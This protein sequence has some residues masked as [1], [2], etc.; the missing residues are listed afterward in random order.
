MSEV[1]LNEGVTVTVDDATVIAAPID[2]TLTISG[3]AA[4]AKAVGDALALKADK[5][6]LSAQVSVNGQS[7]DAQ[8][9]IVVTGEDIDVSTTDTTKMNTKFAALDAKT[10]EDI[11]MSSESS[12]KTIAQAIE[13]GL[14]VTADQVPIA[15]GETTTVAEELERLDSEKGRVK[16]V[17]GK[18]PTSNGN[19]QVEEVAYARNLVSDAA[20]ASVGTFI[21]RM[22]GGGSS[23]SDGTAYL[24]QMRGNMTHTGVVAESFTVTV[25]ST[26]ED[27]ITAEVT[28]PETFRTQAETGGTYTF[29]YT[30]DAWDTDPSTWGM[31]VTGTPADGDVITVVWVE[32]DLGTITPAQPSDFTATGWN[33]YKHSNGYARVLK[34]DYKY[35]VGGTYTSLAY[36]ATPSGNQTAITVSDGTFDIPADGYVHVTG[37]TSTDTYITPEWQ[38]W[39]EGPSGSWA[40]YSESTI[41]VSSLFGTGKLFEYGLL[42]VENTYDIIDFEMGVATSK[43]GRMANTSVNMAAIIASGRAYDADEDYIYYVK[44]NADIT[45]EDISEMTGQFTASDHGIEMIGGTEVDVTCLILYG[46]NLKNKLERDCITKS[47]DIVDNLTSTATDKALSAKQ[48]KVLDEKL[49]FKAGDTFDTVY[50][51][52][53]PGYITSSTKTI[54]FT[55]MLPK[56]ASGRTVTITEMKGSVRGGSGYVDSLSSDATDLKSTYTVTVS[57]NHGYAVTISMVKS[58]AYANVTNNTPIIGSIKLTLTFA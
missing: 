57:Y 15:E 50:N 24:Q 45:T 54:L 47:Q 12:A 34:Y 13:D 56:D 48:G 29:T 17:N 33:L 22:S 23:V 43:I 36:S 1:N 28:T 42:A 3:D 38:D 10:A 26:A 41:D 14:N 5:S 16:T 44:A 11:K 49:S 53:T 21:D 2:D 4:D 25:T 27:P 7:A 8:G 30:T 37:G 58:T 20:A 55:F 18:S 35:H 9:L 6:E 31:T 46:N 19:V 52:V 39:T 32:E 40:A 51:V